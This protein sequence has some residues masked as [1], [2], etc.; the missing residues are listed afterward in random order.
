MVGWLRVV[1]L[2]VEAVELPVAGTN[3]TY[4]WI[5]IWL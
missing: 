2:E 4:F 3:R 5:G 1:A